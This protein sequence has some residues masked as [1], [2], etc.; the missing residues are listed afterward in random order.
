MLF[1]IVTHGGFAFAEQREGIEI[2]AYVVNIH[3]FHFFYGMHNSA[4]HGKLDRLDDNA[5]HG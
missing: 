1:F 5:S 3:F 2:S 4:A